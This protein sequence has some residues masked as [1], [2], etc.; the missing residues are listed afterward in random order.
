MI[1]RRRYDR[2][3]F[4]KAPGKTMS[5]EDGRG[6]QLSSLIDTAKPRSIL[7]D[8][9]LF[10]KANYPK[11]DL[12]SIDKAFLLTK[13]LYDGR[14]PG[15]LACAVGYH[16]YVHSVAVFAATSRLLD[17][18]ELSGLSIGAE[19]AAETLTAALLLT[20]PDISA[21]RATRRVPEPNIRKRMSTGPR[22]SSVERAKPSA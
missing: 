3:P 15:Y 9:K 20:T 12:K 17:G 8:A 10:Y 2:L 11:V 21:R 22:T 7:A 14:Y 13:R 16:D 19:R 5:N 18:C 6:I 4:A 1:P